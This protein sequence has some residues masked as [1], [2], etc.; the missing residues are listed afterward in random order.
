MARSAQGIA[1]RRESSRVR[2]Q[3]YR[4][5][6]PSKVT[7]QRR[8]FLERNKQRLREDRTHWAKR[9]CIAAKHR[10]LRKGVPFSLTHSDILALIPADGMCP[11]LREPLFF[12]AEGVHRLSPS[13]DRIV[14]LHGYVVGNVA[15]LSRS[16]NTMKQDCTNPEAFER[17]AEFLRRH[18]TQQRG[19]TT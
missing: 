3:Q 2:M 9:I 17:L 15:M 12:G 16:A 14:P 5:E 19:T 1:K 4:L 18:L 8:R 7:Q 6:Q 13:I 11:I 10:A